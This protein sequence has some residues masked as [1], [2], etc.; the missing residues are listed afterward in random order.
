MSVSLNEKCLFIVNISEHFKLNLLKFKMKK[1]EF[2][3]WLLFGPLFEKCA[4]C[5]FQIYICLTF[6]SH[7]TLMRQTGMASVPSS[8]LSKSVM[9]IANLQVSDK[10][11]CWDM[12]AADRIA[13]SVIGPPKKQ[14]V[15]LGKYE[16]AKVFINSD[17]SHRTG[18]NG[19]NIQLWKFLLD[20][21]TD[22]KHR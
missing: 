7:F 6:R 15:I 19:G 14:R 21:L 11:P 13:A 1:R 22:Y 2:L 5:F 8:F 20:T 16:E 9:P 12:T 4:T 17:E 18:N 3:L 10:R